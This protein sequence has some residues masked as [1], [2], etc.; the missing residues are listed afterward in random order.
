MEE[1]YLEET[2]D[3]LQINANICQLYALSLQ[4]LLDIGIILDNAIVDNG[5]VVRLRVMRV[6]IPR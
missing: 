5:Q 1:F 4:F 2:K 3:K 6:G